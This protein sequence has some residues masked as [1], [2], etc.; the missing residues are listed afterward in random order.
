MKEHTTFWSGM[1]NCIVVTFLR[2]YA[3]VI[4]LWSYVKILVYR[5]YVQNICIFRIL[6]NSV[7][8]LQFRPLLRICCSAQM[9]RVVKHLNLCSYLSAQP[10][11]YICNKHVVDDGFF[12][13][14]RP[15]WIYLEHITY[16]SLIYVLTQYTHIHEYIFSGIFQNVFL[17]IRTN[18]YQL[19]KVSSEI[20][21]S[22]N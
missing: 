21:I 4:I 5:T 16:S 15:T 8:F 19:L 17:Y 7:K 2:R 14:Y 9:L 22:L 18:R 13:R 10:H 6:T 12:I 11:F 1:F 3:C 20:P